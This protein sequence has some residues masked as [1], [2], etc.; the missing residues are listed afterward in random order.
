VDKH[1]SAIFSKLG[2]NEEAELHRRDRD[3]PL[4]R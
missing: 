3:G 4:D 1:I 2:L